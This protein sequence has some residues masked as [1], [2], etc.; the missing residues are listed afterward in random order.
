MLKVAGVE[1]SRNLKNIRNSKK[2]SL[3]PFIDY[4]N[5]ESAELIEEIIQRQRCLPQEVLNNNDIEEWC[6]I[7]LQ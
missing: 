5:I 3:S 7:E 4:F 6:K 2:S 1:G